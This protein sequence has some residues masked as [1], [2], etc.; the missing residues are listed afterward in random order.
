M[1]IRRCP[2][3]MQI[4]GRLTQAGRVVGENSVDLERQFAIEQHRRNAQRLEPRDRAR[5]LLV[6]ER[7]NQSVGAPVLHHIDRRRLVVRATVRAHEIKRIALGA[8]FIVDRLEAAGMPGVGDVVDDEADRHRG[9]STHRLRARVGLEAERLYGCAHL[10]ERVR[11][12]GVGRVEAARDRSHRDAGEAGHVAYRRRLAVHSLHLVSARPSRSRFD[13]RSKS[14]RD[15]VPKK[16]RPLDRSAV[17]W[18]NWK[19]F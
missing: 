10:A 19:R 13:G 14:S 6:V 1:A 2:R 11:P 5:I 7:Q 8:H 17:K 9:A 4:T 15:R 18:L 3:P 16:A 12:Y